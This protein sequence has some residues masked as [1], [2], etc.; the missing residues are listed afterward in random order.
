MLCL[1][2]LPTA[3]ANFTM[4]VNAQRTAFDA[5]QIIHVPNDLECPVQ[6]Q[7]DLSK[8]YEFIPARQPTQATIPHFA[9]DR[10][11]S[12]VGN[13]T[14]HVQ[15]I[16]ISNYDSKLSGFPRLPSLVSQAQ[17]FADVFSAADKATLLPYKALKVWDGLYDSSATTSGI[18][19]RLDEIADAVKPEDVVV[20]LF[21]GHGTIPAGQEMFYFVTWDTKGP[22]PMAQRDTGLSTAMLTEAL[23]AIPVRRVV[24]IIDS[25]QSG[26]AL[27]ALSKIAQVKAREATHSGSD[28]D[29]NT[30]TDQRIGLYLVA[31]ASPLDESVQPTSA[32]DA[33]VGGIIASLQQPSVSNMQTTW[34]SDVVNAVNVANRHAAEGKSRTSFMTISTGV[35]FPLIANHRSTDQ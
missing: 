22:D 29:E 33:L 18:L 32:D 26:G 35:D 27:E 5:S 16:A 14:L 30:T 17:Q 11:K 19:A 12:Y 10:K 7:V 3:K 21:S 23:R 24:L 9:Y 2:A 6:F 34:A 25:C 8:Q 31:A 15:T 4:L 20:L 28:R 13:A 1:P